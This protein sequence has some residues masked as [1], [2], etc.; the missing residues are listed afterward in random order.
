MSRVRLSESGQM[1]FV[2]HLEELR[3]RV[4]IC[5]LFFAA[6]CGVLFSYGRTLVELLKAP[7]GCG[8]SDFIFISPTEAF[9]AYFQVVL[10]SAFVVVF[11]VLVYELWAFL[12]PALSARARRAVSGWAFLALL[13]FYSGILFAYKVLLPVSMNFLLGFAGGIARPAISIA[14]YISFAVAIL[15]MGGCLFQIP[16][17]SGLLTEAGVLDAG[18]LCKARRYALMAILVVAA[19]VS[20]TQ[21]IFNLMFF[22][23][24]MAILYEVGIFFS[25]VTG[26]RKRNLSG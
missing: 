1:D 2:G 19:V 22:A 16:V 17:L 20:P 15:L 25:W 9:T 6:M 23:L 14:E 21:D 10:L 8:I 12:S 7:A 11:P 4:I 13:C 24:P 3:R 5:L 26:C 18:Q